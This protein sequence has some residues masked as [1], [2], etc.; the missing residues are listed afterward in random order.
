MHW[1]VR[2]YFNGTN[3]RVPKPSKIVKDPVC[4]MLS[5]D[6]CSHSLRHLQPLALW[7][8]KLTNYQWHSF[9]HIYKNLSV[10]LHVVFAS[11]C[12]SRLRDENW[13]NNTI[14]SCFKYALINHRTEHY[15]GPYLY[16]CMSIDSSV[17]ISTGGKHLVD[18]QICNLYTI[19]RYRKLNRRVSSALSFRYLQSLAR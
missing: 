6:N 1:K 19:K 5:E 7:P 2:S 13:K 9:M 15:T 3:R 17:Q 10:N 18:G 8:E 4:K 16:F 12:K 14:L 11:V